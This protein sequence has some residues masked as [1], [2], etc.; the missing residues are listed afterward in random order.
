MVLGVGLGGT[1]EQCALLAKRALLLDP[2]GHSDDAYYADME[3][4]ALE[5]V[6]RLGIGP[7]GL[8]GTVTALSVRILAAPHAYCGP[9]LCG[10]HGLPCDP[11][12]GGNPLKMRKNPLKFRKNG[13][14]PLAILKFIWY[15][16]FKFRVDLTGRVGNF[17]TLSC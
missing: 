2:T 12:C 10:E 1:V 14:P 8:G 5:K 7:Q 6:N 3:R 17:P 9:S 16:V 13:L 4:C 15:N 11:P